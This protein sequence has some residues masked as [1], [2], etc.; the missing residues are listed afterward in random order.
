M[1]TGVMC[2]AVAAV[3]AGSRATVLTFD[4][5]GFTDAVGVLPGY[6][7][8]VDS[9]SGPN[10]ISYGSAF[11]FTPNVDVTYADTTRTWL[12]SF[13]DRQRV[14]YT[15]GT[16]LRV[17]FENVAGGDVFLWGFD[18]AGWPNT[19]YTVRS[20]AVID[21]STGEDLFRA[22]DVFVRGATEDDQGRRHTPFA[23]E[24]PL[25]A[26]ALS[27]VI[28]TSG[29]GGANDNIGIDN[30]AFSEVIPG[31]GSAA[32]VSLGAAGLVRRRR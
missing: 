30:I 3:A 27:I 8:F 5:D 26:S 2:V 12:N 6:G 4:Y 1:K 18:V 13:G 32:M 14:I 22:E 17:S 29:I 16:E 31:P 7:A 15:V 25:V 10:G 19:D 11:G 9:F 28:D 21:D 20:V 23:L 24:M